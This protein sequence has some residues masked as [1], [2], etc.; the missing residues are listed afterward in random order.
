MEIVFLGGVILSVIVSLW[1]FT[2]CLNGFNRTYNGINA[3]M[4]QNAVTYN[5]D[6]LGRLTF[7]KIPYFNADLVYF[8]L[9]EY[10]DENLSEAT[11]G[12][13]YS[14]GL[15]FGEYQR[16]AGSLRAYPMKVTITLDYE[17]PI[18][19]VTRQKSFRIAK[20]AA[21]ED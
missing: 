8:M 6:E 17:S 5:Y 12:G 4:M 7:G 13:D 15:S 16:K 10:L 1:Q 20:G 3:T 2:Y 18:Y 11:I 19:S 21:Y 14:L 9:D